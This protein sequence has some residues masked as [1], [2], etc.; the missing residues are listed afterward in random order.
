MLPEV[1]VGMKNLESFF[2]TPDPVFISKGGLGYAVDGT[3]KVEDDGK[4]LHLG[5]G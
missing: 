5:G 4:R 3:Q 1:K 2:E